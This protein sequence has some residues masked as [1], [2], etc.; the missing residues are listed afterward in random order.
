MLKP[1]Q[2]ILDSVAQ[3]LITTV[4]GLIATTVEAIAAGQQ[5]E[6]YARLEE[7]ARQFEADGKTDIAAALRHRSQQLLAECQSRPATSDVLAALND[8]GLTSSDRTSGDTANAT[9]TTTASRSGAKG[10][11][12]VAMGFDLLATTPTDDVTEST[13]T[14]TDATVVT[15]APQ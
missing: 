14:L 6:Q 2:Q 7:L 13:P 9:T 1:M 8:H 4:A 3:R 15:T 10:R 12:R 5:A 11:R